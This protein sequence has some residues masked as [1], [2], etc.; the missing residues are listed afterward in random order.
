MKEDWKI[1]SDCSRSGKYFHNGRG[2]E[3]ISEWNR[4]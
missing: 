3:N 2:L 4:S 1:F